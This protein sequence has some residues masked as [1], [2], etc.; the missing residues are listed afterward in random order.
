M[1]YNYIFLG[2]NIYFSILRGFQKLEKLPKML[3]IKVF[4]K[5]KTFLIQLCLFELNIIKNI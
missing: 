2:K 4:S 5:I 1:E 3:K